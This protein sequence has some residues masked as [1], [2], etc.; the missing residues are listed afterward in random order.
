MEGATHSMPVDG[1]RLV[2]WDPPGVN[3]SDGMDL[4]AG[5]A[6]VFPGGGTKGMLAIVGHWTA[7]DVWVDAPDTWLDVV[8]RVVAQAGAFQHQVDVRQ[9]RDMEGGF[10]VAGGRVQGILT[11]IRGCPC[12]RFRLEAWP[13]AA[14]PAG[15]AKF[16]MQAWGEEGETGDG[17]AASRSAVYPWAQPFQQWRFSAA[18]VVGAPSVL[19]GASALG[20]R[21]YVRRIVIASNDAVSQLV[22]ITRQPGAVVECQYRTPPG[23]GTIVDN[24]TAPL[25]GD[26]GG[27]WEASLGALSGGAAI[28]ISAVGHT[29]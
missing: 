18:M 10:T 28:H 26:A 21:N 23:G 11:R 4:P 13:L 3:E 15:A 19:V 5:G 7:C 22:T 8:F 14:A 29:E 16:R 12:D 27:T 25:R 1:G 20:T 17:R 2:R 6:A 24:I 9:L